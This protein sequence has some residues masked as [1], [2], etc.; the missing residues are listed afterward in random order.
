M[1]LLKYTYR[2]CIVADSREERLREGLET[3]E[4]L[5]NKRRNED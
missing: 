3:G 1:I 2:T 5:K 4:K